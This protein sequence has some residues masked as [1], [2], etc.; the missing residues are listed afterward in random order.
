MINNG[1]KKYILYN[2]SSILYYRIAEFIN[3]LKI[4]QKTLGFA[5]GEVF[6]MLIIY[7][8]LCQNKEIF[9]HFDVK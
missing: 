7:G 5:V 1:K 2:F 4:K 3:I 8:E 6:S 9:I